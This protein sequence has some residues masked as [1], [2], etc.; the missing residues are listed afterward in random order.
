MV[1]ATATALGFEADSGVMRRQTRLSGYAFTVIHRTRWMADTCRWRCRCT[2]PRSR[3]P[4]AASID[5]I[6]TGGN[7]GCSPRSSQWIGGYVASIRGNC[8]PDS[9]MGRI[10]SAQVAQSSIPRCRISLIHQEQF[11]ADL[12]VIVLEPSQRSAPLRLWKK[13]AQPAG[14]HRES[15]SCI[16]RNPVF[17]GT[18]FLFLHRVIR[19]MTQLPGRVLMARGKWRHFTVEQDYTGGSALPGYWRGKRRRGAARYTVMV[20]AKF[21]LEQTAEPQLT[22]AVRAAPGR[23]I[24]DGIHASCRWRGA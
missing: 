21:I 18:A 17:D 5:D 20:S 8:G 13:A 23:A 10:L 16:S 11:Y 15:L 9:S 2:W 4:M 19:R 22:G 14:Q 6:F 1:S 12:Q 3:L 7:R 24:R